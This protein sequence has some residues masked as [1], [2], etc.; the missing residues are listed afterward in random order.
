MTERP[1]YPKSTCCIPGCTRWS[2]KFPGEW[3]CARHWR[4]LP[5]ASR[6]V[7]R[8]AWKREADAIASNQAQLDRPTYYAAMRAMYAEDRL[9]ARAKRFLIFREAGL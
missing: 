7:L 8:R 5:R 1:T 4:M 2:R 6:T 9:W 3:L